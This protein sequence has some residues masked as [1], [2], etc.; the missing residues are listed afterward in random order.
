MNVIQQSTVSSSSDALL[1]RTHFYDLVV[2]SPEAVRIYQPWMGPAG[3][4]KRRNPNQLHFVYFNFVEYYAE[5]AFSQTVTQ[6]F[7]SRLKE[8]WLLR[9]T[10]G[11]YPVM[12]TNPLTGKTSL[13]MDITQ[14][15]YR[16]YIV[17]F[18]SREIGQTGNFDG[19]YLDWGKTE[20]FFSGQDSGR[21]GVADTAAA[22]NEQWL[23]AY[24]ELIRMLRERMNPSFLYYI[25]GGWNNGTQ[26]ASVVN[27]SLVEEFLG[28]GSID[29][30]ASF[31]W[32]PVMKNYL[33]HCRYCSGPSVP[34]VLHCADSVNYTSA[35][36]ALASSLLGD[37]YFG[38]TNT[39]GTGSYFTYRWQ[40]EYS[41]N[42]RN[43]IASRN[44]NFK[45]WLGE[46]YGEAYE[47][48][49][50]TN[51]IHGAAGRGEAIQDVVWRRD[52][53]KGIV[54]CNPTGSAATDIALGGTYKKVSG[55]LDATFNNGAEIT[56][57]TLPAGNSAILYR[58]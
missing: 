48:G 14:P 9:K 37:G 22:Y 2:F 27:G 3:A 20:R 18:V 28:Q 55:T 12:W 39:N 5:P 58:P 13:A 35:R 24:T 34:G 57:I 1:G 7:N 31:G 15:D 11:T 40:D 33:Y 8:R 46:P 53:P 16:E 49:D 44:L 54:I 6:L 17:S 42:Y 32:G 29:T 45:G 47:V 36:H 4:L 25:N 50:P 26:L 43:G 30:P 51:T 52:F 41:V 56:A 23:A 10:D 19:I 21:K 38:W